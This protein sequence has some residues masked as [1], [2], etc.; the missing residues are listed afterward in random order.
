MHKSRSLYTHAYIKQTTKKLSKHI[1]I[2]IFIRF[3]CTHQMDANE[4]NGAVKRHQAR[5]ILLHIIYVYKYKYVYMDIKNILYKSKRKK[6]FNQVQRSKRLQE[7][8]RKKNWI[9]YKCKLRDFPNESSNPNSFSS[10]QKS[11]TINHLLF[12]KTQRKLKQIQWC[13]ALFIWPLVFDFSIS[14]IRKRKYSLG[15]GLWIMQRPV[16]HR[17]GRNFEI[18]KFFL[19]SG[20]SAPCFAHAISLPWFHF[21][22]WNFLFGTQILFHFPRWLNTVEINRSSSE[23]LNQVRSGVLKC[24]LNKNSMESN[25]N[26]KII[27]NSWFPK[28][29]N[30]FTARRQLTKWRAILW[31]RRISCNFFS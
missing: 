16:C 7:L 29:N 28:T 20:L 1:N 31:L 19:E 13:K 27:P 21:F 18:S 25:M 22:F 8:K 3:M 9:I 6:K 15:Q 5:Q 4:L 26:R 17:C 11:K 12:M 23:G 24:N 2:F 10:S 30:S 14:K